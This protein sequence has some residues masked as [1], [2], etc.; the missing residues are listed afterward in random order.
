MQIDE[1]Y[2]RVDTRERATTI[3]NLHGQSSAGGL[4]ARAGSDNAMEADAVVLQTENECKISVC[5]WT[6]KLTGALVPAHI[7]ILET[8]RC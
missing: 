4:R 6:T 7:C 5:V 8:R 2:V 3:R 1:R